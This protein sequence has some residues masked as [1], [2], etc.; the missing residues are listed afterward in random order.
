MCS[1]DKQVMDNSSRRLPQLCAVTG[2]LFTRKQ[3]WLEYAIPNVLFWVYIPD[4]QQLHGCSDLPQ[5]VHPSLKE[6]LI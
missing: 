1:W 4:I 2:V 6:L 5:L 3:G